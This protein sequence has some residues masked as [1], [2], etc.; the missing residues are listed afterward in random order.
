MHGRT[1][2]RMDGRTVGIPI[3]P[4]FASQMVGDSDAR[5][6]TG[7]TYTCR[8]GGKKLTTCFVW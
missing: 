6:C 3:V 2:A 7:L 1:D 8:R 4:V 5:I